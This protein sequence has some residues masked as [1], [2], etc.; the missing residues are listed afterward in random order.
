[1]S[2]VLGQFY[3]FEILCRSS[4]VAP[5]SERPKARSAEKDHRLRASKR[6]TCSAIGSRHVRA[7]LNSHVELALTGPFSTPFPESMGLEDGPGP[8]DSTTPTDRVSYASPMELL[9]RFLGILGA[10]FSNS[11]STLRLR[12]R[13]TE[14]SNDLARADPAARRSELIPGGNRVA[15]ARRASFGCQQDQKNLHFLA[16]AE[17]FAHK[18]PLFMPGSEKDNSLIGSKFVMQ[19]VCQ[20]VDEID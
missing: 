19:R 8:L 15:R 5:K 18:G 11:F 17:H 16:G 20:E 13:A 14:W 1:M 7:S 4:P 6:A 12:S 2:A 9:G 10:R 3:A